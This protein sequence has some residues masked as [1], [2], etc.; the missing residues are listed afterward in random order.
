MS[1]QLEKS[2]SASSEKEPVNT[3]ETGKMPALDNG[4]SEEISS[5]LSQMRAETRNN[6]S[7]IRRKLVVV[8]DGACGSATINSTKVPRTFM[9]GSYEEVI[10]VYGKLSSYPV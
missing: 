1:L 4:S 6:S 9:K 8:G 10:P 7:Q 2:T 3:V 5:N